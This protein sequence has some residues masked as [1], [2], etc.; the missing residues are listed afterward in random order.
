LR[1]GWITTV[2]LLMGA[3]ACTSPAPQTPAP[4]TTP[5]PDVALASPPTVDVTFLANEGVLLS[6]GETRVVIDGLFQPYKTYA[7]MPAADRERIETSQRP[8]E[9]ID[10][11]LVSHVHGDHF[12]AESVAR[13]LRQNPR[14]TLVTS[15]QVMAEVAAQIGATAKDD[16]VQ[17]RLR[18][19]TPGAGERVALNIGGIHLQVLGLPH[20]SGRNA[21]IQN[22]GYVVSL[23]GRR[24][25]HIGDAD[26]NP[27]TFRKL[28]LDR[29]GIDVAL[30]PV[31]FLTEREGQAIVRDYI[32]PQRLVAIHLLASGEDAIVASARVAF[33]ASDALTK[34]LEKRRY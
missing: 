27:E 28:A 32:K 14:A 13:H 11:V 23:G 29:D 3:F 10:L 15:D 33:P 26:T 19:V 24:I 25:L 1:L 12:H 7:V 6:A 5:P 8:F 31:W 18:D 30:L 22:L 21:S 4:A 34:L 17:T 20:G 9:G 2:A 16:A